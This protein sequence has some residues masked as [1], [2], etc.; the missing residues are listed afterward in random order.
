MSKKLDQLK[1]MQAMFPNAKFVDENGKD[2]M[3]NV[4]NEKVQDYVKKSHITTENEPKS[5][6]TAQD[7]QKNCSSLTEKWKK[8]ELKGGL[9]YIRNKAH[10][11]KFNQM[12]FYM[13]YGEVSYWTN[14]KDEEVEEIL[15]PVPSYEEW[16]KLKEEN[17]KLKAQIA[18][19]TEI[20]GVLPS[21]HSVGN[22]G[23]KIKNQR[24]EINNRLKEI[25]KLKELL[26]ECKPYVIRNVVFTTINKGEEADLE[27]NILLTKIDEV[28]K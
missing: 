10:S 1:L 4:A 25:D 19:L 28:L 27:R 13:V 9:Y 15:A 7:V 26:K 20:V 16:W 14:C 23:Y 24:H 22:L 21:N 5:E 6:K 17:A 2:I 3:E 8:G 12:A 18:K 11:I